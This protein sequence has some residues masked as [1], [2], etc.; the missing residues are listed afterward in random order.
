M[1]QIKWYLPS[2]PNLTKIIKHCISFYLGTT[3]DSLWQVSSGWWNPCCVWWRL[4]S[5]KIVVLYYCYWSY[6]DIF[7]LSFILK[8]IYYVLTPKVLL[9][10]TELWGEVCNYVYLLV[11][12]YL[13]S[14]PTWLTCPCLQT[15][16]RKW[17]VLVSGSTFN[18]AWVV[19]FRKIPDGSG[20]IM[21]GCGLDWRAPMTVQFLRAAYC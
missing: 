12:T 10:C 16:I 19:C 17:C 15:W 11:Y 13:W 14:A 4:A 9:Q 1:L 21:D 20:Y 18:R 8:Q 7:L 5:W 2:V 6:S 3:F